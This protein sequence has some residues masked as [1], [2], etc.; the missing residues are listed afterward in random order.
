MDPR[1]KRHLWKIISE[2]VKGKCAV[3]LTSHRLEEYH[4]QTQV[5]LETFKMTKFQYYTNCLELGYT[6]VKSKVTFSILA[7][8]IFGF[9]HSMCHIFMCDSRHR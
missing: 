4:T 8:Y 3:V 1:T 6:W 9:F 7:H 5:Y 2:E